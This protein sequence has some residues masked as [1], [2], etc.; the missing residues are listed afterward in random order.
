MKTFEEE[1]SKTTIAIKGQKVV[2]N[3]LFI[4]AIDVRAKRSC[5]R[6]PE[7]LLNKKH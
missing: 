4:V 2:I 6:I 7:K 1:S 3:F 5:H